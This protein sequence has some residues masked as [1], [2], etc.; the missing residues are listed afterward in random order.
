VNRLGVPTGRRCSRDL[1]VATM[2]SREHPDRDRDF[3]SPLGSPLSGRTAL[4]AALVWV[5][6]GTALWHFTIFVPDCF[7]GGIIGAFL[8]ANGGAVLAGL[9]STGFT[10]PPLTEVSP[11]DAGVAFVGAVLGL[12]TGYS[13]GVRASRRGITPKRK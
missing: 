8:W 11:D 6:M 12:A 4:M 3:P 2:R 9:L 7:P 1:M 5:S 13:Y 10:R